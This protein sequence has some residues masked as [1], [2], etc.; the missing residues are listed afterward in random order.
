MS[1]EK[2]R[3]RRREEAERRRVAKEAQIRDEM[4]RKGIGF[5]QASSN[6]ERRWRDSE[7]NKKKGK[8]K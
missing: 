4:A 8:K 5:A 3:D 6:V 2:D 7:K 1:P